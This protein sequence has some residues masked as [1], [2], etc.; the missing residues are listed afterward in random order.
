MILGFDPGRDKC[1]I[2]VM[3]E[4]SRVAYHAVVAAAEAIATVL[5]LCQQFEIS[6][7]VMGDQTTS[8]RWK[9]T[10]EAEIVEHQPQKP[11]VLVDE[12]YS[13]LEARDRYWTLY[14]AQGI[15]RLMPQRLRRIPRPIDD[16]VAIIL[17]QR[18]LQ[19]RGNP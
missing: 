13:T 15:R 2:A 4:D 18:Y 8:K 10:L 14:P 9:E 6:T 12:R 16:V 17:I 11:I 1:G 19:K 7:I 3:A 5:S